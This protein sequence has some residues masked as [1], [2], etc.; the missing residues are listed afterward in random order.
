MSVQHRREYDPEFNRNTALLS[1]EPGRTVSEVAESFLG[2]LKTQRIYHPKF[3]NVT[4]GE[5]VLFHYIEIL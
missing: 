2:S 3:Q 4:E 1:E 5:Q